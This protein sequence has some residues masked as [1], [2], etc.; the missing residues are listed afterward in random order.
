[1]KL[2]IKNFIVCIIFIFS[3]NSI[4]AETH[5]ELWG[6]DGEK[7]SPQ[8]RLPDF[9]FAGYHFGEDPLPLAEAVASVADFG[10]QGDDEKDDTEAFKQA[11]E[12]T[13]K[14]V[15]SIP[16]GRYLLSD[17][18]WIKKPN[19]VLRGAGQGKT[20]LHFTNELEDVRPNMGTNSSG[21]KTSGYSWSGGFLWVKGSNQSEV[22]S[23][24]IAEAKRGDKSIIVEN[25]AGLK[26]GQ[27]VSIALSDQRNKTLLKYLY[28]ND[29]SS[30]DKFTKQV[31]VQLVCRITAIETDRVTVDRPFRWDIRRSW[32]PRLK[33]Y[34]PSVSEVGIEE[35]SITFPVKPYQGHF[36]EKGMN[37]IAMNNVSDCWIRNVSIS[38][39]DSGVFVTG[40]FCTVDGLVLDGS[41]K[42]KKGDTGHHGVMLGRDC[43]LTNFNIKTKFIHDVTVSNLQSGNVIKNGVGKNLSF[44][45]H[46]RGPYENLFCNIDVGD[47]SQIWRCGGGRDLGKHCGARGTFWC[48]R[49]KKDINWPRANFGP[50]SLNIIGVKTSATSVTDVNGRWF[51]AIAP[52]DLRPADLHAAQ[53]RRR[54][55]QKSHLNK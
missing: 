33:T 44:D 54:L 13:E 36:T 29:P 42:A 49:A 38:N 53:L 3:C 27:R 19:L 10:A 2:V 7:W 41:R 8:S 52:A 47:G 16:A 24:I 20:I 43:I 22:I 50:N 30:T 37:A 32:K 21:R 12:A 51:E 1:M 34:V 15:I 14:G 46:K 39:C 45:H 6:K 55:A 5:S 26:I 40:Y 48:I 17:I 35:V 9:S 28:S 23:P 4:C 18:L 11:I 25:A 31:E